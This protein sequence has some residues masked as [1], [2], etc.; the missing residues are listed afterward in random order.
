MALL[1][2]K[3][4]NTNMALGQSFLGTDQVWHKHPLDLCDAGARLSVALTQFEFRENS[5]RPLYRAFS[6][7]T[8]PAHH[9][10]TLEEETFVIS[11]M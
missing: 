2:R 8:L 3:N 7:I 9:E 11:R 1:L 5:F 6:A 4:H 10:F